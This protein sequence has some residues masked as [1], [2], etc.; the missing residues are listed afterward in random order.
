MEIDEEFDVE[1]SG[2]ATTDQEC[3]DTCFRAYHTAMNI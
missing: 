1:F 3:V 2:D